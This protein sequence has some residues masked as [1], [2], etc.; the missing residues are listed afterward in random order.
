MTDQPSPAR[1]P[2]DSARLGDLPGLEVLLHDELGS[3]NVEAC[4]LAREG[5]RE[6]TVVVAELQTAGRG[7]LDRR[8][9]APPRS[10]L[11]LSLILRP[12]VGLVHWPWLPLLTGYAV[13]RCLRDL[14]VGEAATLKW[15]NDV[16]IDERK[17][18][19][20]LVERIE[21]GSGPAAI[22]GIGL[23]VSMTE[24][25]LPVPTATSLLL[26]T[27]DAPDRTGVLSG[28]LNTL[29]VTYAEWAPDAGEPRTPALR[30]AYVSACSTLER[31]VRADLPGGTSVTG[32]AIGVDETGRLVLATASGSQAIGAGD[33]VHIRAGE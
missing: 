24:G 1:P 2:L 29:V 33:V 30:A 8:W 7:R 9:E 11:T 4:R 15:P 18:A 13:L 22:V 27:G 5:A 6:G 12:E 20:I 17:V 19:G 26:A 31:N 14:G 28:L 16:L 3:T 23:N 21:T 25:E 10:S 32:R